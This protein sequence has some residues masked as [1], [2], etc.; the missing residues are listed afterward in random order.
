MHVILDAQAIRPPLTGIGRYAF[1]LARRIPSMDG[2]ESLKL[3][4]GVQLT[5]DVLPLLQSASGQRRL[6]Q[7]IPFKPLVRRIYH[8]ARNA[9]AAHVLSRQ[10]RHSVFHEPNYILSSFDGPC[11]ATIHDLSH[12]HYPA[13]H[14]AD[15]V[16]FLERELPRTLDRATHLI[17]VSDFVRQ[18][19]IELLGLQPERITTVLNGVD[20]RFLPMPPA[21]TLAARRRAR[22][23]DR[24]YLLV[25]ATLE[26]RKNLARLLDAYLGLPPRLRQRH[27]LVLAGARGWHDESLSQRLDR[28][29]ESDGIIRLGFV[30]DED[31]PALY[32]GAHAFA[33]A[34]I[35]EGFGLPVLEAMACGVPVLTSS[36][37]SMPEVVGGCGLCVDPFDVDAMR[38]GLIR[39]LED[40]TFRAFGREAGI[41]R[42]RE[43][44]WNR[45]AAETVAVYRK[46]AA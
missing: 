43:L 37:S 39:L 1:E 8:G 27:P 22:L 30:D 42:A 16:D 31:L 9:Y 45:C 5:D 11:V 24:A 10:A 26:P 46:I 12:I 40:E 3:F 4:R 23:G 20:E 21:Q 19:M 28:L 35:Y 17:T 15:R 14:P 34:S 36:T 6:R 7:W 13:F 2:V 33:F 44:G 41:R 32:A 38:E 18:E 29:A 25:V